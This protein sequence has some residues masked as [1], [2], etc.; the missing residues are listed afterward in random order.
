MLLQAETG[1]PTTWVQLILSAGPEVIV[2]LVVT[3]RP[4]DRVLVHHRHEVVAIPAASAARASGSSTRS[5]APRACRDA[6]REVMKLPPSPF[7]R[8]FR[9]GINFYSELKPG[10]DDGRATGHD[11]LTDDPARS[12]E[13]G[14]R[15]RR[16]PP[17]GMWLRSTSRGS[18][19]SAR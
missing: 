16:S 6:Y 17:S 9:E 3:A 1:T 15:A 4:L 7:S 12:A 5:S 14:A 11:T 8:L 19:P 2:V 13:N 10:R 18:R